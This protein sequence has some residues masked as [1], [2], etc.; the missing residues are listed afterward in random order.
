MGL[1]ASL[2]ALA[3]ID[4]ESTLLPDAI[5]LPLAWAGLLVNL[6]DGFT[7]CRWRCWARWRATASCG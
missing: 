2:V 1:S 4:L 3:W 6:G 5:T 7:R